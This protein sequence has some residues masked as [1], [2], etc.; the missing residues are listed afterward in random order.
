MV[1]S[2]SSPAENPVPKGSGKNPAPRLLEAGI[3]VTSYDPPELSHR[4]WL[5]IEDRV[6][7]VRGTDD[8]WELAC[9]LPQRCGQRLAAG[10]SA[11]DLRAWLRHPAVVRLLKDRREVRMAVIDSSL[12][13]PLLERLAAVRRRLARWWPG[14]LRRAERERVLVE[15]CETWAQALTSGTP[16][17]TLLHEPLKSQVRTFRNEQ[18]RRRGWL[19]RV[20]RRCRQ[21]V[22]WGL[23][24]GGL[25][26]AGLWIRLA[27]LQRSAAGPDPLEALDTTTRAIPVEQ[28]AWPLVKRFWETDP[29]R[30]DMRWQL[31]LSSA[32]VAGPSDPNWPEA[33]AK[34]E[35]IG[36]S[37]DLL[38]EASRK[39]TLGYQFR[40]WPVQQAQ[41]SSVMLA[42]SFSRW[43]SRQL[44][45]ALH[46]LQGEAHRALENRDPD[47]AVEMALAA[48]RLA[49]LAYDAGN[50]PSLRQLGDNGV[51]EV[52]DLLGTLC[53][54]GQLP[55]AEL[56]R[57]RDAILE[58]RVERTAPAVDVEQVL[59]QQLDRLYSPGENGAVTRQGLQILWSESVLPG[60]M[61]PVLG[62]L[63]WPADRPW[64]QP[65]LLR[66]GE[67]VLPL[68]PVL[69]PLMLGRRGARDEILRMVAAASGRAD[70]QADAQA[71]LTELRVELAEVV[72][73]SWSQCRYAPVIATLQSSLPLLADLLA[74]PLDPRP[75]RAAEGALAVRLA[76]ELH[77]LRTGQFP[78]TLSDLVPQDLAALPVDP[79]DGQ[80]LKVR[81]IG[82]RR[83]LYSVGEDGR[84]DTQGWSDEDPAKP[85]HPRDLRLGELTEPD[86][87]VR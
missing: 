18:L 38:L 65:W 11:A 41:L 49:R 68:G 47:R 81:Q 25:L 29:W 73:T 79:Y 45:I 24:G 13:I 36:D 23:L 3:D 58:P 21:G 40:D 4:I 9:A 35:S 14:R 62:W 63:M 60:G 61:T 71:F 28:R 32:W 72:Q 37:W 8:R 77:R 42:A 6:L 16:V 46:L 2:S 48:L 44:S 5:E 86:R 85:V 43:Q 19:S 7:A 1:V 76:W 56:V 54:S 26:Y 51:L 15:S 78:A 67:P 34:L 12:P 74:V 39:P 17:A 80:P 30:G 84:D 33:R 10:E 75:S 50:H 87:P 27:W 20:V 69:A 64:L 82:D 70:P 52:V 57:L 66:S 55:A 31:G 53:Q 83:W 59:I 22:L